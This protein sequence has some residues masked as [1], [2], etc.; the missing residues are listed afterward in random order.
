MSFLSDIAKL[1]IREKLAK[2]L[3][4]EIG[5]KALISSFNFTA[6]SPTYAGVGSLTLSTVTTYIARYHTCGKTVGWRLTFGGTLGGTAANGIK[7]TTLPV[8]PLNDAGMGPLVGSAW[9]LE[10]GAWKAGYVVKEAGASYFTIYKSDAGNF[11]NSGAFVVRCLGEYEA[12]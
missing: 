5:L 2:V 6:W 12:S 9:V 3:D 8:T 4:A 10:G 11:A 7:I 1:G